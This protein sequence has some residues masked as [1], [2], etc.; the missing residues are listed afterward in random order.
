MQPLTNRI[1]IEIPPSR[2]ELI[3]MIVIVLS[4]LGLE[5]VPDSYKNTI[6]CRY[7]DFDTVL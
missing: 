6:C 7:F 2:I 1:I 4:G 5:T 3:P